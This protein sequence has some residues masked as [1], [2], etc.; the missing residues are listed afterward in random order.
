MALFPSALSAM[1]SPVG[2]LVTSRTAA[3]PAAATAR[4]VSATGRASALDHRA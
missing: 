3:A 2:P 4:N 1:A